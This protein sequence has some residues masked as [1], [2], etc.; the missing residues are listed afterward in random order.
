VWAA[1]IK[2]VLEGIDLPPIPNSWLYHGPRLALQPVLI[3]WALNC[4]GVID[5]TRRRDKGG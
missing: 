5:W 3:W 2:Q 1:S 4:A